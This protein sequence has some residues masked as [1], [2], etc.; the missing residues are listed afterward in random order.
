MLVLEMICFKQ[1]AL[2]RQRD[3]EKLPDFDATIDVVVV[4]QVSN[5]ADVKTKVEENVKSLSPTFGQTA[6][7]GMWSRAGTVGRTGSAD[8]ITDSVDGKQMGMKGWGD[9]NFNWEGD[10]SK[11]IVGFYGCYTD[12][13]SAGAKA[14]FST[15]ISSL[16]NFKKCFR[17][18]SIKIVIPY[19][20]F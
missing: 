13:D 17:F 12:R 20:L 14:S 1:L 16:G 15:E 10:G 6:E 7:F 8:C 9:I 5:L 11:C 3:I 2:T 19:N 18:R 4:L